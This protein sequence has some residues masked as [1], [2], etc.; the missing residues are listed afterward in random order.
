MSMRSVEVRQVRT[1][2]AFLCDIPGPLT[3]ETDRAYRN[4]NY[5]LI[6]PTLLF[7][8]EIEQITIIQEGV[9]VSDYGGPVDPLDDAAFDAYEGLGA[10]M[11]NEVVHTILFGDGPVMCEYMSLDFH[12]NNSISI[13]ARFTSSP[14]SSSDSSPKSTLRVRFEKLSD[15]TPEHPQVENIDLQIESLKITVDA[16]R[17]LKNENVLRSMSHPEDGHRLMWGIDL[18]TGII[19]SLSEYGRYLIFRERKYRNIGEHHLEGTV[20]AYNNLISY[21][22]ANDPC[23]QCPNIWNHQR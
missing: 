23:L 10:A 3:L 13:T 4:F 19:R 9:E 12:S 15:I 17:K 14:D 6:C 2:E 11:K 5:K 1:S 21:I 20:S 16:F 22:Q 8:A 7:S 18:L